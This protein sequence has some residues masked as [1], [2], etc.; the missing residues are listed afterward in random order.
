MISTEDLTKRYK[1]H[2]AVDSLNLDVRPGEIYGFLGPNGAGKTT[3]I[4]MLLNLTRPTSGRILLFGE[5]IV[6]GDFEYKRQIG[7]VAE[8]P[9][10]FSQMTGWELIR[11]FVG[12]YGVAA[13]ERRME[14]LFRALELWDVRHGLARD[15]SRGMRQK[16]SIIRA[17]AH[18]PR[19]LI[20]DEPVSG[21]DPHGIRQVREL[22]QDY[23]E[24]GG[25]VF[26]SS[27]I[28]SEIERAAD[29]VGILDQ[30]RLLVEDSL[31]GLRRRLVQNQKC[32]IELESIPAGL[33]DRLRSEPYV[34]ELDQDGRQLDLTVRAQDDVR[35]RLSRLIAGAGGVILKM[36][37]EEMSLEEAFVTIT[38]HNVAQLAGVV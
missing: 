37:S 34:L 16:L 9:F 6:P 23:H 25:T 13:P 26:I 28:L 1:N 17:L 3:T 32:S 31:A 19:L 14:E 30:G 22:I 12:L 38:S 33:V 20:L 21:L 27:H 18:E 4:Q 11:Y 10:E 15:Y 29:R 7:V 36:Q 2:L 8:E 5:P 35:A 24:R